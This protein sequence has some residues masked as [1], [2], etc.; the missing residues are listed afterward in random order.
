MTA[1]KIH[2]LSK[3]LHKALPLP[4]LPLNPKWVCHTLVE[5]LQLPASFHSMVE[6]A[7]CDVY[8]LEHVDRNGRRLDVECMALIMCVMKM[9]YRLDDRHEL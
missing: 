9:I 2:K 8:C 4:T 1:D 7:L 5:R 6:K 3:S